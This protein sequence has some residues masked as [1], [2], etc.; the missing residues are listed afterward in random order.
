MTQVVQFRVLRSIVCF[1]AAWEMRDTQQQFSVE[2]VSLCQVACSAGA[3]SVTATTDAVIVH[4]VMSLR[5][6]P[7]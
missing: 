2:E 7:V 1:F 4:S 5:R 3:G 6:K